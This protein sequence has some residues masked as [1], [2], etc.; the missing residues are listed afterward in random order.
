MADDLD[1]EAPYEPNEIP[2]DKEV[3]RRYCQSPINGRL[4]WVQAEIHP[5]HLHTGEDITEEM[6]DYLF[7]SVEM[8]E[9]DEPALII[10]KSLGGKG[11][12][13]WNIFPQ[14][15]TFDRETYDN[16]VESMVFHSVKSTN[17]YAIVTVKFVFKSPSHT[18]PYKLL[19]RCELPNGDFIEN[20]LLNA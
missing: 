14:G 2:G 10:H 19:Y 20:A 7:E 17:R 5:K 18:K 15:V 16:E 12:V 6:E 11:S 4:E 3:V 9:R 13:F 8:S 1:F